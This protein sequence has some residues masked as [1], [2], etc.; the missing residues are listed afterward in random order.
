MIPP[1]LLD[2]I[3]SS[4]TARDVA[5]RYGL[6]V[7]RHG[8]VCCPFHGEKT[9]SMKLYEGDR[10]FH[11]F[12]CHQGGT[13]I[14]LVMK[15]NNQ[16]FPEAVRQLNDDFA[17]NLPLDHKLS[18]AERDRAR[19]VASERKRQADARAEKKR[20]IEAILDATER[21]YLLLLN[22]ADQYRPTRTNPVFSPQW[23]YAMEELP[24]AKDQYER[25]EYERRAASE[26][27]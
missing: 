23:C 26:G 3:K 13:V 4:V 9:P 15:L 21:R 12:G 20:E 19:Q 11:C 24:A 17:L 25:M 8:F 5:V 10:G 1:E 27:L 16:T 14:D 6:V 2:A 18:S 22:L 7:S